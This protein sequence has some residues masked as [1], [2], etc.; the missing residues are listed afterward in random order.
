MVYTEIAI[1]LVALLVLAKAADYLVDAASRLARLAGVTETV[2]G[3]TIVAFGTTVPELSTSIIASIERE[4][5]IVLG[6]AVGSTI[7]NVGLVLGLAAVFGVIKFKD[8]EFI[9]DLLFLLGAS[10]ILLI[11][12]FD[13]SLGWTEGL[14]FIAIFVVYI[15]VKIREIITK[16][17]A[18]RQVQEVQV[19]NNHLWKISRDIF[20]IFLFGAVVVVATRA[21]VDSAV[22]I[23]IFFGIPEDIIALTVIAV[24]TSLPELSIAVV[25]TRK[26]MSGL[27]IGDI[28]GSSISNILLIL[29][30]GVLISPIVV[31]PLAILF[32][33]P[34]MILLSIMLFRF[35]KAAWAVRPFEGILLISFYAI[36][37][38]GVFIFPVLFK[39]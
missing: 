39:T 22:I 30:V 8:H 37:V 17:K 31:S 33:I 35:I 9:K 2:I 10:L 34:A 36:F 13:G 12:L 28:I 23:S 25:G 18:D 5:G 29:G 21:M 7:A 14:L 3:L 38:L 24:G 26:G 4:G 16:K 32:T 1:F 20:L 19:G 6:N 27:V 15:Y 11:L